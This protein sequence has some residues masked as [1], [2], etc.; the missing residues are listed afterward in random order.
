MYLKHKQ[1]VHHPN[2]DH[3]ASVIER[4]LTSPSSLI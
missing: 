4:S 3:E 1:N 2:N